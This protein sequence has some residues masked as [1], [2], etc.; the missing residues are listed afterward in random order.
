MSLIKNP[1]EYDTKLPTNVRIQKD[2]KALAYKEAR[3]SKST[4]S[5]IVNAAL[6]ERYEG[7]KK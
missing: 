3:K 1:Q 6:K 7:G 4:L 5:A 2:L